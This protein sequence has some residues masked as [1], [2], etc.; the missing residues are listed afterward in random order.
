MIVTLPA[1]AEERHVCR[2]A[3]DAFLAEHEITHDSASVT[4]GERWTA[5]GHEVT[6][7]PGFSA[8]LAPLRCDG[9]LRIDL[10]TACRIAVTRGEDG[11]AALFRTTFH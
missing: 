1:A 6:R 3:V 10:D 4:F 5:A 9:I 11:C 7:L 2:D 8:R